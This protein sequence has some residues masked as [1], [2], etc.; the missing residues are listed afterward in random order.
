ML[1]DPFTRR[2]DN[3]SPEEKGEEEE[4]RRGSKGEEG[5]E[6]EERRGRG[7]G[8]GRGGGKEEEEEEEEGEG[9]GRGGRGSEVSVTGRSMRNIIKMEEEYYKRKRRGR[10][11]K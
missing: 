11:M 7:E 3:A 2:I 4:W 9:R 6:V 5:E 1:L 8:G 10:Q